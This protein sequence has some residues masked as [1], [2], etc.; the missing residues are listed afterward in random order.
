MRKTRE[1]RASNGGG[2]RR[3]RSAH[4]RAAHG[5]SGKASN[6]AREYGIERDWPEAITVYMQ[7][8][9]TPGRFIDPEGKQTGWQMRPGE[10]GDRDLKFFD[11]M[12]ARLKPDY[13]VDARARLCVYPIKPCIRL[14]TYKI[15]PKRL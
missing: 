11:A 3:A 13:Q 8:L 4:L 5:H 12:I 7:G 15:N 1:Q 2:W 6:A 10:Q 14:G 9:N